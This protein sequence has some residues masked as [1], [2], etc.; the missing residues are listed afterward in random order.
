MAPRDVDVNDLNETLQGIAHALES[1]E[2]IGP[3]G[4]SAIHVFV[5]DR[6]VQALGDAVRA[7]AVESDLLHLKHL[8]S[9]FE[10]LGEDRRRERLN[11]ARVLVDRLRRQLEQSPEPAKPAYRL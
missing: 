11:E 5:A 7:S 1:A 9:D 10:S 3:K 2:R 8:F 6:V 4:R